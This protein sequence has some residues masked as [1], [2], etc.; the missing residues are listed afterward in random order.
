[1]VEMP[2]RKVVKFIREH[3]VVEFNATSHPRIFKMELHD[4]GKSQ[5]VEMEVASRD[6]NEIEWQEVWCDV[7]G[8]DKWC[9]V[10]DEW[11]DDRDLLRLMAEHARKHLD[12]GL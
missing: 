1:M 12:G 4:M 10:A 2:P 11:E 3:V 6:I 7:C 8:R 5:A 9:V